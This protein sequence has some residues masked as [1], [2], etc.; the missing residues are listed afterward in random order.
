MG[1]RELPGQDGGGRATA[2]TA[3]AALH[4]LSILPDVQAALRG[5][6]SAAARNRAV[7]VRNAHALGGDE[8]GGALHGGGL[9]RRGARRCGGARRGCAAPAQHP[10][11][12]IVS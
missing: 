6:G 12:P 7:H 3:G 11:R 2:T 5:P 8:P 9:A 4:A 10:G 1:T